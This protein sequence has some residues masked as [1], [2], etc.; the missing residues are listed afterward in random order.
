M[1]LVIFIS[2]LRLD[3]PIVPTRCSRP[4]MRFLLPHRNVSFVRMS[5][6][7]NLNTLFR[8]R[9]LDAWNRFQIWD[10][11]ARTSPIFTHIG[12]NLVVVPPGVVPTAISLKYGR[13]SPPG[14]GR[15]G[16]VRPRRSLIV[17]TRDRGPR[18]TVNPPLPTARPF[19]PPPDGRRRRARRRAPRCGRR[20]GPVSR[21]G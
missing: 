19:R 10:K 15:R 1:E 16:I 20:S 6:E 8:N 14:A 21:S 13:P 18:P 4:S 3:I 5:D 2:F 9:F 7:S 12:E 11:I 17:R